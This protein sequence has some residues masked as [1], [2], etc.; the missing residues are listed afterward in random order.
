MN[1]EQNHK[2]IIRK[3]EP[4]DYGSIANMINV[5]SASGAFSYKVTDAKKLKKYIEANVYQNYNIFVY[6]NENGILGYM[7]IFSSG[8][9]GTILGIF[10][11]EKYRKMGIG[12]DMLNLI[13]K[14]FEEYGCYKIVTEVYG[15]N[16]KSINFFTK[17][18]FKI[19][20]RMSDMEFH[21]DILVFTRYI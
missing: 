21:K 10:V 4:K 7:D 3:A 15:D 5:A 11:D 13:I 17:N 19:E 16:Y 18:N 1:I 6:E 12:T 2:F 8:N 20:C 14:K 9:V